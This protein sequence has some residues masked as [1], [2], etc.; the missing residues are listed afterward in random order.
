[1]RTCQ[2]CR[3]T[4]ATHRFYSG[5]R[6]WC[7][8]CW[9]VEAKLNYAAKAREYNARQQAKRAAARDERKAMEATT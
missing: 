1:M 2:G 9:R 3:V 4:N 8:A 6:G 7:A 5:I